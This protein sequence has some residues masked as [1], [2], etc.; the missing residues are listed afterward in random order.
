MISIHALR[1][2]SDE[3][4]T[5]CIRRALLFQST[6]SARRATISYCRADSRNYISIHALREESDLMVS[7][8]LSAFA[9][10]SIHALREESDWERVEVRIF[11]YHFN[12]RSPRGERPEVKAKAKIWL[13]ISIHALREESD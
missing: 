7:S 1:E 5:D 12:P 13:K 3:V 8:A 6:L 2:E 10:I 9:A 4:I 11:D